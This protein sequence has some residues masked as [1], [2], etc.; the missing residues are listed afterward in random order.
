MPE[1]IVDGVTG[2]LAEPGDPHSLQSV[3]D[4]LLADPKERQALGNAGRQRYLEH[5]TREIFTARTLEFYRR[6]LSE[7]PKLELVLSQN[8]A[9]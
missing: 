5:Y 3:L 4:A 8:R 7:S 2:L 6:I 1:V 9:Y